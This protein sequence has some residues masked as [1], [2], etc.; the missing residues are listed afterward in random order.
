MENRTDNEHFFSDLKNLI[1]EYFKN[2][3][4]IARLSVFEKI[5][6]II[7]VIF[8]AIILVFLFFLTILLLSLTGGFYLSNIFENNFYGFGI[9]AAFFLFLFILLLLFRK[10]LLDKMIINKVI[11][12]LFDDKNEKK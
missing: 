7:A 9:M 2:R 12:I 5:A 10:E 8:S 4:E 1:V 11:R 6:K 3:L